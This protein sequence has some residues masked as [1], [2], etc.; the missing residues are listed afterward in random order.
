MGERGIITNEAVIE[1]RI[2]A[3][4]YF[5]QAYFLNVWWNKFWEKKLAK[6]TDYGLKIKGQN[7]LKTIETIEE[8]DMNL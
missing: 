1:K 6:L 3:L 7:V 8:T 5:S 2:D 4:I